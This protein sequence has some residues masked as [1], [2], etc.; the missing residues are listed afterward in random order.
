M[1]LLRTSS[2]NSCRQPRYSEDIGTAEIDPITG[3]HLWACPTFCRLT[4]FRHEELV[5][6]TIYDYIHS[7]DHAVVRSLLSGPAAP[8][9]VEVRA[10]STRAAQK[11]FRIGLRQADQSGTPLLSLWLQDISQDRQSAHDQADLLR[12]F[13]TTSGL[14]HKPPAQRPL[15]DQCL[16]SLGDASR[17]AVRLAGHKEDH[18][19]SRSALMLADLL[20]AVETAEIGVAMVDHSGA[21][22]S[23]NDCFA[24]SLGYP[25]SVLLTRAWEESIHPSDLAS[26]RLAFQQAHDCGHSYCELRRFRATGG[27][28]YQ[29]ITVTRKCPSG[30]CEAVF[31]CLTSDITSHKKQQDVLALTVESAPNG[32]LMVS[33]EGR[34]IDMNRAAEDLLG[35]SRQELK[36]TPVETLV[37]ARYRQL[38]ESCRAR[39]LRDP[40]SRRMGFQNGISVVRKDGVEV[41]VEIGLNSIDTPDGRITLCAIVDIAERRQN[42]RLLEQAKSAAEAANL[43]KS[44][45]L[46]RMSHEIRTPMNLILGMSSLLLE[47]GLTPRQREYA[48]LFRRNSERLLR[49]I[50]GLLDLSKIEAGKFAVASIPFYLPEVI[51]DAVG[52]AASNAERKGLRI[53][54]EVD[55]AVR[56]WV[57]GDPERLL[58]VFLNLLG[59][60]VKFTTEGQVSLHCS[61]VSEDHSSQMVRFTVSDTGCG[62]PPG[63]ENEIFEAFQQAEPAM[64]RRFGGSGLGL[65]IA[66]S[67]VELMGGRI[68]LNRTTAPGASFSFDLPFITSPPQ[69]LSHPVSAPDQDRLPTPCRLRILIVDDMDD[70][71]FLIR[72]FLDH[73]GCSVQVASNGLEAL[74]LFR[75]HTFDLVLMDMQ[76]P[77]MDGYA[78]VKTIRLW[79]SEQAR[80]PATILALTAHALNDAIERSLDAGCNGHLSKPITRASLMDAI[81]EFVPTA[82]APPPATQLPE[83]VRRLVPGYLSRRGKDI[84]LLRD[85][86]VRNDLDLIRR[87]A[88]DWKGSGGGYGLPAISEAGAAIE[89]AAVRADAEEIRRQIIRIEHLLNS[90]CELPL[91]EPHNA[92]VFG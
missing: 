29:S 27:I 75:T 37:P 38:H 13:E 87:L 91:H 21:Y 46:A 56:P 47:S 7:A 15:P 5:H 12:L 88:H 43:A 58:Q 1:Q 80:A 74:H 23:V 49:L 82:K 68:W 25:P 92:A 83:A 84:H 70:N 16:E 3:W 18:A 77:V 59:N 54:L 61:L 67:L 33:E 51:Q 69:P 17:C 76:M 86:L 73:S 85:A 14:S 65:S 66:R 90:Q 44:E 11:W 20:Q 31:Y 78:A 35:Y 63:M 34:V 22:L 41:P 28:F 24:R 52:T 45:F 71:I 39:Y 57:T 79:E 81:R 30:D 50:N 60:A 2:P 36:G 62:V 10:V 55:S 6:S 26:M 53:Q 9:L 32:F 4:G 19:C 40:S 89:H 8:P 42:E 64:T 48:Q 72:C